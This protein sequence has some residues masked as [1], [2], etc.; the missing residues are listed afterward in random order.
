MHVCMMHIS[1][2][3]DRCACVN[4]VHIHDA[5]M[6]DAHIHDPQCMHDDFKNDTCQMMHVCRMQVCMSAGMSPN[7]MISVISA[8]L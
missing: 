3:L 6:D 5:H 8:A 1:M 4:D 2:I 7:Y